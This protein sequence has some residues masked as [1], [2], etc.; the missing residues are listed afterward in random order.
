MGKCTFCGEPAG[1]LKSEHHECREKDDARRAEQARLLSDLERDAADVALKGEAAIAEAVPLLTQRASAPEL[2]GAN[3]RGAIVR[4]WGTAITRLL[5]GEGVTSESEHALSRYA[6]AFSLTEDE[7]KQGDALDRLVKAL[8]LHDVSSGT[9]KVRQHVDHSVPFLLKKGEFIL[10]LFG[11]V[12]YLQVKQFTEYE[13]RSAGVSVRVMKG[14]YYR[15]GAFH[16]RPVQ[17][18]ATV[19]VDTGLL[20]LTQQALYFA[21]PRK[22]LRLP[23]SKLVTVVPYSDG[24]GIQKDGVSA[25]PMSFTPLDGWFTYNLIKNLSAL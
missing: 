3:T 13:G 15:T 11:R 19:E 7:K 9:P 8:I 18:D 24:V 23:Y 17:H 1:F 20:G 22:S 16:G 5:E 2:A 6:S 12:R 10:W 4:G 14:V 25:K 21:G